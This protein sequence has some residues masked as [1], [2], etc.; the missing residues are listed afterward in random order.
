M[1][2]TLLFSTAKQNPCTVA[3]VSTVYIVHHHL[4]FVDYLHGVSGS[5]HSNP[6]Y[7][8]PTDTVSAMPTEKSP[9]SITDMEKGMSHDDGATET[10][11]MGISEPV[12]KLE[13]WANKLDAMAGIEARGIDRIPEELRERVLS[14]KDYLQMFVM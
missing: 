4:R 8:F 2:E 10:V 1:V 14:K 3:L 11:Q 6:P 5:C 12:N 7:A 13:R 9:E